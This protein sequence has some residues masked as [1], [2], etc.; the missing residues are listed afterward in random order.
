ML[1]CDGAGSKASVIPPSPPRTEHGRSHNYCTGGTRL[2]CLKVAVIGTGS[3][4]MNHLRVLKDF[5]EEQVHLVGVAE[6]YE[7]SLKQAVG[8]FHIRGYSDYREMVEKARPDLVAV[9]VPTHLHF[10][11]ASYVL[12]QGINV[13]VEKPMT[14]TVE[15]ALALIQL[16]RVRGVKLAVGHIERFNPAV[17][18]VRQ[19]LV[20]GELGKM[21]HLHAR[22][23][24][25][26]PS[27]IRDVGV[28]LD[29]ATH[30]VDVMRYL[31]DAEVKHVYAETQRHIH[32]DYEDLLLGIVRF[33]NDAI[34][35]LDVNWLTPT[36][37]RE[38]SVTGE[39]GMFL[40]NYLTQDIYFYENDYSSTSWDALRSMTGVNEGTM[41]R[42]KVQKA[43]PLRLEYEDVIQA[44]RDNRPPTVT[45]EDG[46][47]ALKV[48]YQ[49]LESS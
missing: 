7:P 3:M 40:V 43:E 23:I 30:D 25:P 8:R 20:A 17:I 48:I 29:L 31:V 22:R 14:S 26:F 28:T 10:E 11:V 12:D 42:L 18:A 4:G 38:L 45:G 46:L 13:L 49:L 6:T 19:H 16:A 33:T 32:H 2:M 5:N 9:V 1:A 34:G 21:F 44:L 15:E 41:T 24:G 27:R 37:I 39:K 47:A 35:M 36:K